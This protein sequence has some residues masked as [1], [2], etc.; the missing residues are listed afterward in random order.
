MNK[1][2]ESQGNKKVSKGEKGLPETWENARWYWVLVPALSLPDLGRGPPPLCWS[3]WVSFGKHGAW[4]GDP[5]RLLPLLTFL[6]LWS[7]TT[8]GLFALALLDWISSKTGKHYFS[9]VFHYLNLVPYMYMFHIHPSIYLT[10]QRNKRHSTKNSN[11]SAQ[12]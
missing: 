7:G 10:K 3:F 6:L 1:Q 9:R 8:N 2:R 11:L 4:L 5:S 12:I